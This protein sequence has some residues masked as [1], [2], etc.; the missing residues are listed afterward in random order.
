MAI[1]SI[2]PAATTLYP[3][4]RPVV[5]VVEARIDLAAV[6]TAKGSALVAAD[7]IEAIRIPAKSV[8]LAAGIEVLTAVGGGGTVLTLDLGTGTDVDAFVD[9][10][11]AFAA[12]AGG[13]TVKPAAGVIE[14]VNAS[15]TIDILIATQTG[16]FNTGVLRVFAIVADA[17]GTVTPGL[18]QLKS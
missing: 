2:A 1:I 4:A 6:V 11:D 8:V 14:H 9:G 16:V 13:M 7:V 17:N 3:A 10:Y 18:A 12:V 5:Y 15:D